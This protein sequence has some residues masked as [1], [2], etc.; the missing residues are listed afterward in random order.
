MACYMFKIK[1][2]P[3]PKPLSLFYLLMITSLF[4]VT[5]PFISAISFNFTDFGSG[6]S[7]INCERAFPENQAIQLT[8][9]MV[10]TALKVVGRATYFSPMHLWDKA[11]EN[12]TDFTTHFSFVID[13]QNNTNYANE[14]AFFLAPNG[15]RIPEGSEGGNMGLARLN[16]LLKTTNNHFLAVEFDIFSNKGWDPPGVHVCIDINSM[17]SVVNV[18]WLG[19]NISIIEGRTN[20]AR[21]NY[22]SSSH[23][24]C[25]LSLQKKLFFATCSSPRV[26]SLY[27]WQTVGHVQVAT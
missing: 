22:N 16:Q 23:K 3:F 19:A 20:E 26:R 12:L 24:L 25:V 6:D 21:I 10:R 18:S 11:S 27:T 9:N 4:S 14:L 8:S 17:E 5:S 7:R 15:S 2:F 1:H 13:S